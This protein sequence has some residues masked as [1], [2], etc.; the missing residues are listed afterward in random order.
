MKIQIASLLLA[1]WMPAASAFV[2]PRAFACRGSSSSSL[3]MFDGIK[4]PVQSYVDIWTPTFK[5]IA[6]SGVVPEWILHWGHGAAM[7]SVLL[8]MGVIGAYLGWQIRLGNGGGSNALTLGE[9]I[10]EAHPKIIGG[11][12]FFFIVG[13]QGGLVLKDTL[14]A[15][16]ILESPHALTGI[17]SIGLLL[18]QAILPQ[19]FEAGGKTARDVHAYLGSAT[20]ILLFGHMATGIQLGLSF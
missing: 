15:G 4:E 8:S 14:D 11:A 20:M 10:R 17:L 6:A 18:F 3:A 7:S 2:A 16:P 9:T 5:E 19:F 1:L 13:G 12:L